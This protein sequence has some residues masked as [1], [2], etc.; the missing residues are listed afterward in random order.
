MREGT[1]AGEAEGLSFEVRVASRTGG[2]HVISGDVFRDD[3]F[4]ASFHCHEPAVD[5]ERGTAAGVVRFRG[6]RELFTGGL[7]LETDER[8]IGSFQLTVD[9][10]GGYRDVFA[11][12][13]EWRGSYLRRLHIEIDGIEGTT[14][15]VDFRSRRNDQISIARAFELAG[16]DA[17]VRV[18]AFRGRSEGAQLTRGWT[19]A[20][21][22]AAMEERRSAPVPDR[23]HVHVFVC[24][25]LAGRDGRQ[26]LGIMYDFGQDDRNQQPREGIAIFHDHPLLS[27]PRQP[28]D[29]RRR[30]YVFTAVHEIGHALNLLHSFDKARPSA[31]SW[32]NYPDYYPLGYERP[33]EYDGTTEFWRRFEDS[34]DVEELWHLHHATPREIRPGG[35]AFGTYEEGP[36]HVFGGTAAPRRTRPGGNPL[37]ATRD[38]VLSVGATKRLYDLGEPV[39]LRL[40]VANQGSETVSIPDALDPIDGYVRLTIQR[41]NG[42]MVTYR[43]P[44]RLCKEAQSLPLR[45]QAERASHGIPVF[46]AAEGAVFTDPGTYHVVAE[47]SGV[48]GCR[49]AYSEPATITIRA[50]ESGAFLDAA[51]K[52]LSRKGFQRALYLRHPLVAHDDWKAV[53]ADIFG[54]LHSAGHTLGSYVRY[55]EA[56]GWSAPFRGSRRAEKGSDEKKAIAKLKQMRKE[57]VP[58]LPDSVQRRRA[59]MLAGSDEVRRTR[60]GF[61][62]LGAKEQIRTEVPPGGVFG[63][64]GLT[65]DADV[66]AREGERCNPLLRVVSTFR[67]TR[68][69]ADVVSWNIEHLE[70]ESGRQK[71]PRIAELVRSFRCDFWGLQEVNAERLEELVETINSTGR[72]RYAWTAVEGSGQQ[73]GAIW[74]TDTTQVKVLPPPKGIEKKILDVVAT[75]GKKVRR[76]VFHRMPLFCEVRIAQTSGPAF[77]FRCAIAHLKSTD[78]GLR[79]KGTSLRKEAAKLLG[80][81]LVRDREASDEGDYLIMGDLNAETASQGL[82]PFFDDEDLHVMSVG[83]Q[84]KY[85]KGVALTRVATERLLDHLVVTD[86][87]A[88]DVP[89]NEKGEQIIIR[90]DQKI[91]TWTSDYSDHVPVAVRFVLRNG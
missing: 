73:S 27:D 26:V 45:A 4:V 47:M 33:R 14:P 63:A 3:E 53:E 41:P 80:E 25:F 15:P 55:V 88:A 77:D 19:L 34:F 10:E 85:G 86:D 28:E 83:M 90:L 75:G 87:A 61:V 58:A 57:D 64:A 1:Y 31:L 18:D 43:P 91:S 8:G 65:R 74:R 2:Q 29:V 48:D 49:V 24:S 62:V 23:I 20:E 7:R 30:E 66:L 70:W 89:K 51:E 36:S 44:V 72:V 40:R 68:G 16:F 46:L 11:G 69:F 56:L 35:Y 82:S 12:R 13:L 9:L 76:S 67:G 81:W 59:E 6:H 71:I 60:S 21:I 84:K 79:D 42:R 39:F 38:V 50:P 78:M 52:T 32:M 37:R 54:P 17:S 22:H 5:P